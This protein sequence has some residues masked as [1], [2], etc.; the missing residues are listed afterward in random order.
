MSVISND[1]W[2]D[3]NGKPLKFQD[4]DYVRIETEG[5]GDCVLPFLSGYVRGCE[6]YGAE[7]VCSASYDLFKMGESPLPGTVRE[8]VL[9]KAPDPFPGHVHHGR[10]CGIC[11]SGQSPQGLSIFAGPTTPAP[12]G[13]K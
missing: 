4:G 11:G 8:E 12:A 9:I 2:R 5:R 7:G 6:L 1:V 10:V 3:P 13:E